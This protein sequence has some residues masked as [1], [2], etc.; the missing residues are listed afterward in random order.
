VAGFNKKTTADHFVSEGKRKTTIYNIINRCEARGSSQFNQIP[1]RPAVVM[2][3]K[4]IVKVEK[5]FDRNSSTS[6]RRVAEKLHL[7]KST[8]SDI[9]VKKLR[10]TAQTKKKAPKYI[11]DQESRAKTGL[12]RLY[13]NTREK[14]LIIDDETYLIN[15]PS[16][17]PGRKWVHAK[18]HRQLPYSKRVKEITKFP[19]KTMVW[20]AMDEFGNVSEPYVSEGTMTGN[21]YLEECLKKRLIPFIKALHDVEDVLFWPD[22]APPHYTPEARE[23]LESENVEY[24]PRNKNPPNVPQARGIEKFWGICKSRYSQRTEEPNGH[25]GFVRVWKNISKK[26]GKEV[27][28][29]VMDHAYRNLR[30]IGYKGIKGAACDLS[31]KKRV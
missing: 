4:N 6:V 13:K 31:K 20:Q 28:K 30:E 3:K 26:V 8:V 24:V 18:D 22:L 12:R 16:Q 15:D 9:K 19:K 29:R 21:I 23:Y 17:T 11:K 10:Y 5:A 1:G 27:G 14:I 2:C 7:K 25:N